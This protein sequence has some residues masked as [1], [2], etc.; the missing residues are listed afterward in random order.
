MYHH[1][2]V[3]DHRLQ[4]AAAGEY[5]LSVTNTVEDTL[6][7]SPFAITVQPGPVSAAHSSI[8]L[9]QGGSI[10]AGAELQLMLYAADMFGNQ[11]GRCLVSIGLLC[12]PKLFLLCLW[13]RTFLGLA[14]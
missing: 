13:S 10:V 3:P 1:L 2:K 7:G 6:K 9:L 5:S 12:L 14:T 4:G 8:E 11:V